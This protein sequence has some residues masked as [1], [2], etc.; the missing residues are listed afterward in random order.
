MVNVRGDA[1]G[2]SFVAG[3]KRAFA[4]Y[5]ALELHAAAGLRQLL[6]VQHSVRLSEHSGAS[7]IATWQPQV[8]GGGG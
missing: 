1:G 4:D 3:Y 7:L 5:S 2:G 6:S 8:G